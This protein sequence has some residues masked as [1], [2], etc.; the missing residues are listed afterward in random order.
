[1]AGP[2]HYSISNS[3]VCVKPESRE[4]IKNQTNTKTKKQ[5]TPKNWEKGGKNPQ[6][7]MGM[8]MHTLQDSCILKW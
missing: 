6:P 2:D 5:Q 7:D 1:M 8:F 4:K 3:K